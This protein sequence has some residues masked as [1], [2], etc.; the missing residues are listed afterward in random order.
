MIKIVF[1]SMSSYFHILCTEGVR[2]QLHINN[3]IRKI[4]FSINFILNYMM[5]FNYFSIF[6][7]TK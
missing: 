2:Q 3:N 6:A 1:F 4:S 7:K 5:V